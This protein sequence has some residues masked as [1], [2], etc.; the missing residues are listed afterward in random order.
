M[1]VCVMSGGYCNPALLLHV[2][3]GRLP[4]SSLRLRPYVLAACWFACFQ[5]AT[6]I[7]P[8]AW[9]RSGTFST[10]RQRPPAPKASGT[11]GHLQQPTCAGSA[12]P[13]VSPRLA[14]Q[15]GLLR[16]PA[17]AGCCLVMDT[18]LTWCPSGVQE[19]GG[20]LI[21]LIR[22]GFGCTCVQFVLWLMSRQW[23]FYVQVQS[24]TLIT[25]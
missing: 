9:C 18:H 2:G 15:Q 19:V 23:L 16:E 10:A 13:R 12:A 3:F 17:A 14:M 6:T 8:H 21:R 25:R 24:S 11:I 22:A 7:L 4:L 20:G 5:G 1:L